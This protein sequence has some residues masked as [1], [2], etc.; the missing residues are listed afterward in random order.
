MVTAEK[1]I[2][3]LPKG[4]IKWY[5]F[6]EE[7]KAL[8]ISTGTK[9]DQS[10]FHALKEC[11]AN[12]E[13]ITTDDLNT[14]KSNE[15]YYIVMSS[16]IE[17][18]V[19]GG[20][21][22]TKVKN[23]IEKRGKLFIIT[24][25]RFAVRYFC[26]DK[27]P[28]TGRNFDGVENYKNAL[29]VTGKMPDGRLYSKDE[30][31]DMLNNVGFVHH[32]FYSVF[33]E[34]TCPQMLISEEY[35]PNE[36]LD[37][38]LF[39]R[40]HNP[41]IIFIAEEGLYSQLMANDMLHPMANGFLIECSMDGVFSNA[42]QV[43]VSMERGRENAMCTIVGNDG[44]VIKKPLYEEGNSKLE[45]LMDNNR[46]LGVHGVRMVPAEIRGSEFVMPYVRGISIAAYLRALARNDKEALFR[47]YDRLWEIILN[48]SE[49]VPYDNV[50]WE[51]FNP[52]WDNE[53]E[54]V[55]R[56]QWRRVAYGTDEDRENLGP[57]L[58]RGYIDLVILNGFIVDGEYI[59]YDQE[60]YVEN[61]PAKA[62]M[63]RNI[64]LLFRGEPE[65]EKYVTM[66]ELLKRYKIEKYSSIFS[67]YIRHFLTKLRN[68]DILNG[69]H[70]VH[71]QNSDAIVQ[72]RSRMNF[73][74]TDYGR[75]FIDI[76]YN[77][78]KRKI[79]LFGAGG[80]TAQFI[81]LYQHE[82]QICCIAD[83]NEAKWGQDYM[84]I[85]I[86][87][88]YIL[89]SIDENEYKV[90]ICVKKYIPVVEQLNSIGLKDYSIYEP[91]RNYPRKRWLK[92][93][94][95][96]MQKKYH[97]GYVAGVFDLFHIGHLNLLRRAKEQCDYLI[98]G[99]VNDER[100]ERIKNK[101][102]FIPFKERL[103]IVGACKYVDEAVEIPTN[104]GNTRD[105]YAIYHFDC[106]FTGDDHAGS[107]HWQG[108][109]KYLE[110]H[111]AEMIFFP[112]T[113]GTSSTMLQGLI[114]ADMENGNNEAIVR[115]SGE[116]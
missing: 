81:E 24:D 6:G 67:A 4:L 99:V 3:E 101:K 97:V 12:T 71:R 20:E 31:K 88:P 68:D 30:M 87:S 91:V 98:A 86:E 22:L 26:G 82:F 10:L 33:P 108:E 94:T 39:P 96:G 29:E 90:I 15:Y 62:V 16:A 17:T 57:I 5:G 44:I 9:L 65:L 115:E 18:A 83:N 107:P 78:E 63:Q 74:A 48:S 109:K 66:S 46:Y 38:R 41:D 77:T 35:K 102:P 28:Y 14:C 60:T 27:D 23:L 72:N 56:Q 85:R 2:M 55:D 19:N 36:E 70:A 42:Q 53:D 59:F 69:F 52:W 43:T 51:H 73:P 112:Y 49:H 8:Y 92:R 95:G 75:L 45:R 11:V 25:N 80:N 76:F 37:I 40:Y 106:M 116:K 21:L 64:T 111:G 79:I 110:E 50:E 105:A 54:T 58:K 32:K 34:I 84:G 103:E 1:L 7:K 114:L 89:Y 13:C 47:Q 100:A 61:L 113:E 104:F 93:E